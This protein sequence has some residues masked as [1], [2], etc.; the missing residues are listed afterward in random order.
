MESGV[1]P[2]AAALGSGLG[3]A[4]GNQPSAPIPVGGDVTSVQLISSVPPVYPQLAR[5]QRVSGEV[6]I[7]ALIGENG[8]VTG[9]KVISGPVLLHQAAMDA[10]RQ[11]KYKP[12]TLNGKP[13]SMHLVVTIQFRLQ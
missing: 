2:A 10:L 12:A 13:V 8:R 9:T 5:T 1:N 6:K 4:K 11:W 3:G 7:D